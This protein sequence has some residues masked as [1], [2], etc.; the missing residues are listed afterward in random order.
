MEE[1]LTPP[2]LPHCL[3]PSLRQPQPGELRSFNFDCWSKIRLSL[4]LTET[5][6]LC[7]QSVQMSL[8]NL[9]QISST[10]YVKKIVHRAELKHLLKEWIEAPLQPQFGDLLAQCTSY[11]W[12]LVCYSLYTE[13]F[14]GIETACY[15][16]FYKSWWISICHTANVYWMNKGTN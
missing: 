5:E 2:V 9:P 11:I 14:L 12:L 16:H 3:F 7:T 4:W 8:W 15:I 13:S 10:S 6:E 1:K